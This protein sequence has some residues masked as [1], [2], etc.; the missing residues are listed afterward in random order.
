MNKIMQPPTPR[1][2][3]LVDIA[4]IVQFYLAALGHLALWCYMYRSF[5]QLPP[6]PVDGW[7]DTRF[8]TEIFVYQG[9]PIS[10][11][12]LVAVYILFRCLLAYADFASAMTAMIILNVLHSFIM[13][14]T[15]ITPVRLLIPIILY[16]MAL[17]SYTLDSKNGSSRQETENISDSEPEPE[18]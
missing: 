6:P 4:F 9:I 14:F 8:V 17:H 3:R 15:V 1:Q 7:D 11:G 18:P 13:I 5:L 12:V 16:S 10:F 2:K